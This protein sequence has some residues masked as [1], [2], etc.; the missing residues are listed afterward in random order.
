MIP[1]ASTET[2]VT[3]A[4]PIISADAVEAVRCGFRRA[5][6]RASAPAAPPILAAGQPST[7]ANGRAIRAESSATPKKI[8]SVPRPM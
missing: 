3:S 5:L 6:S 7:H 8:N 1:A 4:S 2:S